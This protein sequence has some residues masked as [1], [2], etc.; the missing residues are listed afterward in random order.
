MTV[1]KELFEWLAPVEKGSVVVFGDNSKGRGIAT[2]RIQGKDCALTGVSLVTNL[3]HNLFSISQLG[4][5]GYECRFNKDTCSI[6]DED[7]GKTMLT[8]RK[9]GGVYIVDWQSKD[10]ELSCL[11]SGAADRSANGQ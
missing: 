4:E 2:G 6:I 1:N 10:K 3:K 8:G 5:S 11:V 7:T 9:V